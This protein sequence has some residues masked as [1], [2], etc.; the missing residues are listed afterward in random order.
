MTTSLVQLQCAS[1]RSKSSYAAYCDFHEEHAEL[2]GATAT[3]W[4][5]QTMSKVG[6]DNHY[7]HHSICRKV[8]SAGKAA[9][10]VSKVSCQLPVAN[11]WHK[12]RFIRVGG[13]IGRWITFGAVVGRL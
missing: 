8:D 4:C 10:T 7:V 2:M 12:P 1:L 6:P 13:K 5:L 3:F 11:G 9:M